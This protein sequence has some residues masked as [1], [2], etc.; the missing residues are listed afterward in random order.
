MDTYTMI[1]WSKAKKSSI[2]FQANQMFGVLSILNKTNYL[3]PKYLTAYRKKDAKE[4]ELSLD[5]VRNIILKNRDKQFMELGS[6]VSFFTSLNDNESAGISMSVGI[7]NPRFVNTVVINLADIK[8]EKMVSY[9]KMADI[10]K[11]MIEVYNP[12]YGCIA[13]DKNKKMFNGYYDK[14]KDIPTSVFDVNYWGRDTVSHLLI[15]EELLSKVYEYEKIDG[16]YY[17]RLLKEPIDITK[18]EHI[19]LQKE[20]NSLLGI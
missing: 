20:I 14:E 19:E 18:R 10:F 6:R 13:C 15:S 8:T 1:L 11:K 3:R 2:E 4:F 16:G 17:I 7:S 5:N 9:H 12:F